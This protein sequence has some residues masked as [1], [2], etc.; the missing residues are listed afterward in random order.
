MIQ[1]ARVIAQAASILA[2]QSS[3]PGVVAVINAENT[4]PIVIT[5]AEPTGLATG[6]KVSVS[7]VLGNLAANVTDCT[8]TVLSSTRF[9]LNGTTASG[10][11]T[12]GGWVSGH[13]LCP[14]ATTGDFNP[15]TFSRRDNELQYRDLVVAAHL[16]EVSM[17][18][19]TVWSFVAP[20]ILIPSVPSP[21][22]D[23]KTQDLDAS[24]AG[25][26][27]HVLNSSFPSA[28]VAT[29]K[30]LYYRDTILLEALA[31]AGKVFEP[32]FTLLPGGQQIPSATISDAWSLAEGA[33][34]NRSVSGAHQLN[35]DLFKVPDQNLADRDNQIASVASRLIAVLTSPLDY[36]NRLY[37]KIG[38]REPTTFAIVENESR[39]DTRT[40]AGM[41]QLS[42]GRNRLIYSKSQK[43]MTWV[44]E[45]GSAPIVAQAVPPTMDANGSTTAMTV[46]S[47]G[48]SMDLVASI[49]AS[50][51]AVTRLDRAK[52]LKFSGALEI[53]GVCY[54]GDDFGGPLLDGS[55]CLY[56]PYNI[57]TGVGWG[58][59]PAGTYRVS[60]LVRPGSILE[61]PGANLTS[62]ASYTFTPL[63]SSSSSRWKL[64]FVYSNSTATSCEAGTSG[65]PQI[66]S[67]V[68]GSGTSN[69]VYFDGSPL[70]I[71]P[72]NGTLNISKVIL[73][74]ENYTVDPQYSIHAVLTDDMGS[75]MGSSPV[76][77]T[78]YGR[79]Q[80]YDVVT[81]D[82]TT[83]I[84][85]RHPILW[86][87]TGVQPCPLVLSAIHIQA[88]NAVTG[89]PETGGHAA[90]KYDSLMKALSDV[91]ASYSQKINSPI[92]QEHQLP[93]TDYFTNRFTLS[94]NKSIIL[95]GSNISS[96]SEPGEPN[97]GPLGAYGG[98]SLW[99]AWTATHDCTVTINYDGSL[100]DDEG[101]C[102]ASVAIYTGESLQ[103]LQRV[104]T[105]SPGQNAISFQA[106]KGTAYSIAVDGI[107]GASGS[108]VLA[109][110]LSTAAN[111]LQENAVPVSNFS[112]RQLVSGTQLSVPNYAWYLFTSPVSGYV[113]VYVDGSE[114]QDSRNLKVTQNGTDVAAVVTT[115]RSIVFNAESGV[116]YLIKIG[117][118]GKTCL[119]I[120]PY[121]SNPDGTW[122]RNSIERWMSDIETLHARIKTAFRQSRPGDIGKPCLLPR[123][124]SVTANGSVHGEYGSTWSTPTIVALQPWMIAIGAY[125]ADREFWPAESTIEVSSITQAGMQ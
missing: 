21:N 44:P 12:S 121:Y 88:A 114:N 66:L 25:K 125:V 60:I 58:E 78:M 1:S 89:T 93:G 69:P 41:P 30:Q 100:M 33:P 45:D 67:I 54:T 123:G 2:Q 96:T 51:D 22:L 9:R 4:S 14:A 6:D 108:I 7:G 37:V 65:A 97:H 26:V 77:I 38:T 84:A 99:W 117:G 106:V 35:R 13:T 55:K 57:S 115:S 102:W 81:F 112:V 49:P 113:K 31:R 61:F 124:L 17:R 11:Y 63:I 40:W 56:T 10:A 116:D 95:A 71:K 80:R 27:L 91:K 122:D 87:I 94:F 85:S 86:L 92:G 50:P 83:T 76:D 90:W 28:A 75:N 73:T 107:N 16:M 82:F 62:G 79:R 118:D 3:E 43:T 70:R 36:A 68:A 20:R 101:V 119:S 48:G 46:Q 18:A 59:L 39:D 98:K 110:S 24:Q 64:S 72:L 42:A 103:S 32:D 109:V 29:D 74:E 105:S 111:T 104:T 47:S 15:T 5:T 23:Y 8:I 120:S 34:S 19:S 53:D 52:L